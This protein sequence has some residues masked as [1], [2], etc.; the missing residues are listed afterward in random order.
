MVL[1][2]FENLRTW[3]LLALTME[4]PEGRGEAHVLH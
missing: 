1:K 2:R 4:G 3:G